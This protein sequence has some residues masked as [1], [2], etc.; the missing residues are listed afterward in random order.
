MC[1]WPEMAWLRDFIERDIKKCRN[2]ITAG[3]TVIKHY[4]P[5]IWET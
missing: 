4:S 5:Q 2:K 1:K 3:K